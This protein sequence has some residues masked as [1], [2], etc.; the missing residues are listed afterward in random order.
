MEKPNTSLMFVFNLC[1]FLICIG[2]PFLINHYT[3]QMNGHMLLLF[4]VI[5][6]AVINTWFYTI[7][8]TGEEN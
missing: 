7:V 3:L 6:G 1:L 2:V 5:L 8:T 4:E